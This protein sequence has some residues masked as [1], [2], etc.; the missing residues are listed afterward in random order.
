MSAN[1]GDIALSPALQDR[2]PSQAGPAAEVAVRPSPAAPAPSVTASNRLLPLYIS[3]FCVGGLTAGAVGLIAG[4]VHDPI[5]L[6]AVLL[7]VAITERV[8]VPLYFDGRLSL[9]FT[10]VVVAALLLGPSATVAVCVTI[11]VAGFLSSDRSGRKLAFNLGQHIFAG[12]G[13]W[14]AA[15]TVAPH[16]GFAH[17]GTMVIAG[18]MAGGVL[19]GLTTF[20]VAGAMALSSGRRLLDTHRK[21][22][23]WMFPHYLA[24]GAVA[25]GLVVVYRT[26]GVVGVAVMALPL[27]M[28]RYAM[29]QVIDKTRSGVVD[30]ERSHTALQAAHTDVRAMIEAIP[31]AIY[32]LS[33][34]G[35]F[36]AHRSG[37][38]SNAVIGEDVVGRHVVEVLPATV[39]LS[40]VQQMEEARRTNQ[41]QLVEYRLDRAPA[42]SD[43][44]ARVVPAGAG[45]LL[46]VRDIT[47]RKRV[48]EARR[49]AEE[50]LR[51]VTST[52]PL[53]LFA[54]DAEGT[55]TLVDGQGL[56]V[57]GL[58]S[59]QIIGT[60]VWNVLGDEDE[61]R[62]CFARAICGES[63]G[64]SHEVDGHIFEVHY[65]PKHG[66]RGEVTGI[67]GVALDVT[68]HRKVEAAMFQTQKLESLGVLAGGVA[69]DFNNLLVGIL[70]NAGLAL[71]ELSAD[72]P[73]RDTIKQIEL[74][75]HRAADLARQIL[76]YSGKGRIV[77]Q[78]LN[79]NSL[80]EETA[81]L[82]RVSIKKG[83]RL[84]F[85]MAPGL[86]AIEADA[87]QLRQVVMNLVVNASDAIGESEGEIRVRTDLIHLTADEARD[88]FP[89]ANLVAGEYAC[90]SVS[91]TGSGMDAT[92][93]ARIFEPFFTTKFTGRGLGLAAVLGI[94]RGHRGG[95]RVESEPGVGTTFELVFPI[96][97]DAAVPHHP[98][99]RPSAVEWTGHGKVL[100]VDDEDT[101]RTV[102]ARALKK[103]GFEVLQAADGQAG[104][105]LYEKHADELEC[106]LLDMTMPRLN[107]AEAFHKIRDIR[108]D[109]RVILMTGYAEEEVASR[110]AGQGL[111][112]FVQ[113]PY[114]LAALRETMRT[115]IEPEAA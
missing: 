47:E 26:S 80:V 25:G 18:A 113:K 104:V 85:S 83:A 12:M 27:V 90:L 78:P 67:I 109:A 91:D 52:A 69:H 51:T 31:D 49:Q 9:S 53:L 65:A 50:I 66:L 54:A 110:F 105:D 13:A 48:E 99:A 107:G 74:A 46:M 44:E 60:P 100:I 41:V 88:R 71:G 33:S 95:L 1:M 5:A 39:A 98:V 61:G 15:S 84:S 62:A 19:F 96:V 79:L 106:V 63:F 114:D 37:G 30:L 55:T 77:V 17:D 75:G 58:E 4:P 8:S 68:E 89:A 38:G 24:L 86:S 56:A 59:E 2:T 81:G 92:T 6:G 35:V 22:F 42:T 108:P 34:T 3:I 82:L 111:S 103:F 87:T 14:L 57:L 76:A 23:G 72:D 70:A 45:F 40:L 11:A 7:F 28:S 43:F 20:A 10:G 102:T 16:L 94:V 112:G 93:R 32:Q 101:V 73:A 115:V 29:K 97:A 21:A 36:T 64:S